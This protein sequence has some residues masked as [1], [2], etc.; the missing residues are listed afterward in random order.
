MLPLLQSLILPRNGVLTPTKLLNQIEFNFS[1]GLVSAK[2]ALIPQLQYLGYQANIA[3]TNKYVINLKKYYSTI[4]EISSNQIRILTLSPTKIQLQIESNNTK[5]LE[6]ID[7]PTFLLINKL[8][9]VDKSNK[10]ILIEDEYTIQAFSNITII[11]KSY[12][13]FYSLILKNK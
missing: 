6:T 2:E 7:I 3:Y 4:L 12:E 10:R 13:D 5:E 1:N 11:Y 8:N 9:G